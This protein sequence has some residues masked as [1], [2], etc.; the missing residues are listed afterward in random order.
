MTIDLAENL[1]EYSEILGVDVPLAEAIEKLEPGDISNLL[2]RIA[3][4]PQTETERAIYIEKLAKKVDISKRAIQ[5]DIKRL[6]P[7]LP[8][9]VDES[10]KSCAF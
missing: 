10:S 3:E 2:K 6:M 5:S 9:D 1:N 4:E 7:D 8:E